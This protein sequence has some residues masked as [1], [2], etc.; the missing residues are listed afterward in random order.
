LRAILPLLPHALAL[1]AGE[2]PGH[3]AAGYA[4][5]HGG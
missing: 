1:L 2:A 3:A 4:G 5:A